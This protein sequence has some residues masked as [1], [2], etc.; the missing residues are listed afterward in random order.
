MLNDKM[1]CMQLLNDISRQDDCVGS[2]A[3]AERGWTAAAIRRF[4]G[5]P[6]RTAPNPVFRSAGPMRLFSLARVVAAEQTEQWQRWRERAVQRSARSRA[7]ADARRASLLAEI[8]ALDIRV[9][10]IPMEALAELSVI[11]RNRRV[12]EQSG[13][14]AEPA[15]VEDVDTATLQ[16]WMVNYLRHCTTVYDAA[17]DGLYARIGRAEATIALRDTIYAVIA[18]TY[19]GLADEA[20]RQVALQR[21]LQSRTR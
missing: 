1:S 12:Q 14:C 20:R 5:E 2:G 9:P 16:R 17:L 19:P 4:L 8:A 3:L 15:A 7:I 21:T 11:H 10:R 6:D 13:Y 18:E